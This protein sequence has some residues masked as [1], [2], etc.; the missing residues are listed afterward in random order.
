MPYVLPLKHGSLL[1]GAGNRI[2]RLL[3]DDLSVLLDL[4]VHDEDQGAAGGPQDV[5]CAALE[6]GLP[7]AKR[8]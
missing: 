1:L 7:G 2:W 6:E 4:V 5:G 3:R 8:E